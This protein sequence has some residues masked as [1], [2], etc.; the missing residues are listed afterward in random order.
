MKTRLPPMVM[1]EW[2]DSAQPLPQW[3]WMDDLNA[4]SICKCV[5]VGFLVK[6]SKKEK[7]IALSIA[8]DAKQVAGIM[9]IPTACIVRMTRLT[10]SS[11]VYGR[12]AASK[13]RLQGF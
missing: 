12:G 1:V 10:S 7:A 6:D 9:S 5:T 11:R 8:D 4:P 2:Q 13:L 3:Q